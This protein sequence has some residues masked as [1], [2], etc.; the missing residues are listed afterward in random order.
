VLLKG[1][2]IL[3]YFVLTFSHQDTTPFHFS[4]LE[5]GKDG[6]ARV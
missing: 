3:F 4:P 5:E 6:A 2:G 1:L